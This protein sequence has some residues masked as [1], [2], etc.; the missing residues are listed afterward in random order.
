MYYEYAVDPASFDSWQTA[1][2]LLDGF[3]FEKGRLICEFPRG[4]KAEVYKQ[5]P[6]TLREI[7]RKRIEERLRSLPREILM[8]RPGVAFNAEKPWLENAL[9]EH[10]RS[11]FRAV[12]SPDVSDRDG[13]VADS[14]VVDDQDPRWRVDPGATLSRDVVDVSES[15]RPLLE[16][17]R[18]IH[19]IDPHFRV[20]S[21]EKVRFLSA[22]LRHVKQSSSVTIHIE[23]KDGDKPG[24]ALCADAAAALPNLIP[25]GRTVSLVVW[26]RRELGDRFHNRYILADCGGV[27]FG[28]GLEHGGIHQ[29][30]RISRMGKTEVN[31]YLLRY[32]PDGDRY[33]RVTGVVVVGQRA[34]S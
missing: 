18:D 15:L 26:R 12:V 4:W 27:Q 17:A 25:A 3:G 28:D 24:A 19:L 8:R 6:S 1:R 2:Y 30:D 20:R 7:E 31:D 14:N 22:I 10:R 23:E 16:R 32:R 33:D 13:V 34:S 11:P 21:G 9:T 5:L 29:T